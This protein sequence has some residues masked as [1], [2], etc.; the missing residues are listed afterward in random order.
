MMKKVV[1]FG[2]KYFNFVDSTAYAFE[3]LGYDVR[4]YYMPLLHKTELG[5]I[6]HLK[7][8]MKCK[9]FLDKFYQSARAGLLEIVND[10]K[11]DM[12]FS[13]NGNSYYEF[14]NEE[15]LKYFKKNDITTVTWYMDTVKRF[16]HIEQNIKLFDRVL[17]F[18]PNDVPY[19]REKYERDAQYLPIGVSEELYCQGKDDVKKLYDVSFVGNPSDKRLELLDRVAEYCVNNN[20]KMIVYGHYWHNK[21]WWQ[22]KFAKKKFAKQHPYLVDFIHN[23]FIS[24]DKVANLYQQSKVCLNIHIALHKGVNPRTFEVMGNGNFELCDYREDAK[25]LGLISGENIVLYDSFD[26]CVEKLDYYLNN[27]DVREKIAKSA[28]D[29]VRN[30]Y[31]I[32]KLLKQVG[33]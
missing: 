3:Q 12:V 16:E 30:K 1:V 4:I 21:H 23:G 5:I 28:A 29:F 27:Y 15:V 32:T 6:D 11:P 22:E 8:K 9:S 13:I 33:L 25:N 18:E 26:E 19:I 2:E 17:V 24:G 14:V 7:Y 31:T 20:K 10:F